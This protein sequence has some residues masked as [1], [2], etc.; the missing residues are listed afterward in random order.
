MDDDECAFDVAALDDLQLDYQPDTARLRTDAKYCGFDNNA[1]DSWIFP[2]N[3]PVRRYQYDISHAALFRNTLVVLPTGLGK[4]FL[5]AVVMYNMYRWYPRGRV[6]FMA[7]TRPLVAQQI[8]ACYQ[9][10][11]L[12]RSDTCELTGKQAKAQRLSE[13]RTKRVF[14][15]TPQVI[16]IDMLEPDFPAADV[17]LLVVDEAHKARGRYAY[18]EVVRWLHERNRCIRVLALSATPGRS[19]EDVAQVVRNL[20]ISEVAVRTEQ[21]PDV[22][23]Y[24]HEKGIRTVVVRLGEALSD[25]HGQLVQIIE[26]YVNNLLAL[27]VIAGSVASL[28]KGWLVMQQKRFV[29]ASQQQRHP[30]HS[31]AMSDFAASISLYHA[32]E[33]LERHGVRI[34]LRFFEESDKFY[35]SRDEALRRL[36]ADLRDELG[37]GNSIKDYDSALPVDFDFGHPKY[38]IL[39]EQLR[40][41]FEDALAAAD[42]PKDA[43]TTRALV[44]CEYKDSVFLIERLLAPDRPLLRPRI[45]VGQGSVTQR[46][47]LATM[48]DFRAGRVNVLIA[49]CVAEEGIDVGEIDLIVCFDISNKNPTRFVQ[50]IGRTGRKRDGQVLM[51][52]T[53]GR[54]QK[55]LVDVMAKKDVTNARLV[56]SEALKAV[57]EPS[58]RLVPT[59]FNPKCI[60]TFIKIAG[61][62]PLAK[63]GEET[64]AGYDDNNERR[65]ERP[66][67]RKARVLPGIKGLQDVRQFFKP[68][69][70]SDA[71]GSA[72]VSAVKVDTSVAGRPQESVVY[73]DICHDPDFVPYIAASADTSLASPTVV[74]PPRLL[75]ARILQ[76]L[77]NLPKL[78][79]DLLGPLAAT[80]KPLL[81][82][83]TVLKRGHKVPQ[84]LQKLAIANSMASTNESVSTGLDEFDYL[85]DDLSLDTKLPA[86]QRLQM[87]WLP[88]ENIEMEAATVE[89]EDCPE[90]PAP[91]RTQ[92]VT[93]LPLC[94]D[95]ESRYSSYMHSPQPFPR[96]PGSELLAS[97]PVPEKVLKPT[98][99][100]RSADRNSTSAGKRGAVKTPN[101]TTP[102]REAFQKVLRMQATPVMEENAHVQSSEAKAKP[103]LAE[104][105]EFFRLQSILDIFVDDFSD[106]PSNRIELNLIKLSKSFAGADD[107]AA[108]NNDDISDLFCE[109]FR[110]DETIEISSEDGSIPASQAAPPIATGPNSSPMK[111]IDIGS[112]DDVFGSDEDMFASMQRP[113]V[114]V[115][116]DSIC[117]LDEIIPSSQNADEIPAEHGSD[118]V[119]QSSQQAVPKLTVPPS[120]RQTLASKLAR[121]RR[122]VTIDEDIAS[123]EH[124]NPAS[125]VDAFVATPTRQ[126]SADMFEV[127]TK[128]VGMEAAARLDVPAMG[129]PSS[130]KENSAVN[131]PMP[132]FL[133]PVRPISKKPTGHDVSPSVLNFG[134]LRRIQSIASQNEGPAVAGK[135]FGKI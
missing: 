52:V 61:V 108:P 68:V 11:G 13:W 76:N 2:T 8:E 31:A 85:F 15:V 109:S 41:H 4:T 112:F 55:M 36:L 127:S 82:V 117:S 129:Q 90:E 63:E 133:S 60:E 70:A 22:R 119:I 105:L 10:M 99:A 66:K 98:A 37:D 79:R 92:Y 53:E 59:E 9:I 29:E 26:P 101:K 115:A 54:E 7:P 32:L 69:K 48:A 97:T 135:S 33:L 1:G 46:Q 12:P 21:S 87:T 100:T 106:A 39:R 83:K 42:G 125:P 124:A 65:P 118:D 50:R 19:V 62:Q 16:A 14:F 74:S 86:L 43:D 3:Y 94:I 132:G 58:P 131:K 91:A 23:P 51:L 130:Q 45:F 88:D 95:N 75:D 72:A 116:A 81:S 103:Q 34:F 6:V 96:R 134:R 113:S 122:M 5:A 104:L 84:S 35:L 24:T 107:P 49:T 80:S 44:F 120:S 102:I 17:R 123:R 18:V 47:Q 25:V 20:R 28:T 78:K 40:K 64:T 110:P 71:T 128:S 89:P 111:A 93:Q 57:M 30:Q 126:I 77:K 73:E 38:G 67:G 27:D 121:R 56:N 114:A